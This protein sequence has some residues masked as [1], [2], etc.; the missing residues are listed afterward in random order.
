MNIKRNTRTLVF[1]SVLVM[2]VLYFVMLPPINLQSVSFYVYLFMCLASI[3]GLYLVSS[4]MPIQVV[5]D[6]LKRPG[7]LAIAIAAGIIGILFINSVFFSPI[8]QSERYSQRININ[9]GDFST[10]IEEVNVDSLPL[11]DKSS[12]QSIG[13]RVMGEI[14]ELI[15]QFSVSDDYNQINYEDRLVRVTPLDY[16]DAFKW[17][18]NK[19]DGI[20]GYIVVDSTTGKATFN[21]IDEG[22]KYSPSAI[23]INNLELHLRLNYPTKE[24]STSIFEIDDDGN[25]YWITPTI[26]YQ[27]IGML[28]EVEGVIVTNAVTGENNYYSVANAPSWVDNVYP[29]NLII[30]QID[31]WGTYQSGFLNSV[32]G[33]KDVK[34]TTDGYTYLTTGSDVSLYT[35]LTS[36]TQ[37]ESNIGFVLVNLRTKEATYYSAPGAEEYS[38]MNSASG[39]VQEKNYEPTFPLLTNVDGNPTYLLSLKDN[40]GLV[41]A[42]ALVDVNDYQQVKVTDSSLGI[43]EAINAYREMMGKD[44]ILETTETSGTIS[45]IYSVVIDGN[46]YYFFV[47]NDQREIYKAP[48]T[49]SDILPF[50]KVED[51]V[52]FDVQDDGYVT[53]ISLQ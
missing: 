50:I 52:I 46:S 3:G 26:A 1:I 12:T 22:I 34:I 28:A 15:S 30:S 39:A 25:P 40:A 20:P 9:T 13:D 29:A 36:A 31:D 14:P 44:I 16:A 21:R 48:I 23:I 18:I 8:L 11:L 49:A 47:I 43:Q 2:I 41:K 32:L 45:E 53:N 4:N 51:I 17:F 27:G 37:D 7:N 33:Q 42:Y 35:G 6:D 24:L 10:D 38:A 19:E 5:Q